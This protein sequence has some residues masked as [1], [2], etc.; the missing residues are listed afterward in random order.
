MARLNEPPVAPQPSADTLDV[1][2]RRFLRQNRE[3]A[4]YAPAHRQGK[5]GMHG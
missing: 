3:L 1:V 5:L 4:K 2:K